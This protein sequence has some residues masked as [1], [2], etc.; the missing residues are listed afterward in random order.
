ME[1]ELNFFS[2]GPEHDYPATG[3]PVK[4]STKKSGV[5]WPGLDPDVQT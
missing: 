4:F 5:N 1:P 3:Y 2:F